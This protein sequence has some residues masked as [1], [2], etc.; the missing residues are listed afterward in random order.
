[1]ADHEQYIRSLVWAACSGNPTNPVASLT[2]VITGHYTSTVTQGGTLINCNEAGGNISFVV[3]EG[4]DAA[5]LMADCM[6]AIQF[7]W[8][9]P[10][11][12]DPDRM[13]RSRRI[14]RI[15]VSFR[16]KNWAAP[17]S[18]HQPFPGINL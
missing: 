6:E 10:K 17:G 8:Q 15:H 18:G 13:V 14:K 5:K 11:G 16:R 4:C 2:A 9:F 1:M 7:I 12:T 3:P